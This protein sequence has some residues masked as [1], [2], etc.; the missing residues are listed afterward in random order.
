MRDEQLL[1]RD[2]T[3]L[4]KAVNTKAG[5]RTDHPALIVFV[6]LPG[7]GKSYLASRLIEKVSAVVLESDFLRKI[8][9]RRPIYTQFESFRLF[10]AIHK[11]I[12]EILK[13]KHNVILDATNLSE[14]SRRPLYN[15][16]KETGAKLIIIHLNTPRE[17]AEERLL[18][19][20]FRRDGYSDAD[21]TVYQKLEPAFEP[22][23]EP[24]FE[25]KGIMDI[26]PVIDK[27]VAEINSNL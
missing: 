27:I 15:I 13:E 9:V 14:D 5:S 25:V 3:R 17:V 21:W 8:L 2:A 6:G 11:L 19:R 18:G 23:R 26:S 20:Q 16:A 4:R 24:H 1:A 12:R 10:H 22:I 7:S